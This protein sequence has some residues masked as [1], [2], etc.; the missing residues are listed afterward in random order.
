MKRREFIA[1]VGGAV[2]WSQQNS[3]RG[4]A[5]RLAGRAPAAVAAGSNS[6]SGYVARHHR[7][8]YSACAG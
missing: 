1:L 5:G 4:V 2:A 7:P 3:K 6:E 8:T